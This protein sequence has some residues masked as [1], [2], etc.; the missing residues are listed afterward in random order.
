MTTTTDDKCEWTGFDGEVNEGEHV[1][2]DG[3][4]STCGKSQSAE[5]KSY[6]RE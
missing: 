6:G 4:C 3:K 2:D 5:P 1:Y